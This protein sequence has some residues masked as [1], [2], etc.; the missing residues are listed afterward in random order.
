[1]SLQEYREMHLRLMRA[2]DIRW[3]DELIQDA[4]NEGYTIEQIVGDDDEDDES[5]IEESQ[6][7]TT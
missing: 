3:A 1:M 2:G 7:A 5:P 6:E 4:I